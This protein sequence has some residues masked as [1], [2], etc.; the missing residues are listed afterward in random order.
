[1]ETVSL[2]HPSKKLIGRIAIGGSKS[3]SNRALIL[4]ALY[5]PDLVIEHL[6]DSKDTRTLQAALRDT[7]NTIDIG[8]AGTAM[9]FLTAYYAAKTGA[10]VTLKGSARMHQ[11][12]IGLLVEAL[13]GLDAEISYLKE[14]GY[15]PLHI[16][17][18]RLDKA[19][20]EIDGGVSSQFITALMLIAPSFEKG[21]T[22]TIKGFSVSTPYIYLTSGLMHRLGFSVRIQGEQVQIAPMDT[23]PTVTTL[24]VEPDWSSASYWFSMALLADQAELYLPFFRAVS[25]QGD[26][27]IRGLF[28]PLGVS[29]I[30]L[31][32]GFRLKKTEVTV[33]EEVH[34]NLLHAPDVAQTLA[35][36][37][38]AKGQQAVL[39]GLQTLSIKETDRLLALKTELEKC[40]AVV[41]IDADSLA[42]KKGIQSVEDVVFDTWGDHRMAMAFAPLALLGNIHINY[43]QVV[44]KSY[45]NFWEDLKSVGF[46]CVYAKTEA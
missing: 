12:P 13:R 46:R 11:R 25:M 29:T 34:L 30:G 3:E 23:I 21:L 38:A 4:Q 6:S 33:R 32:N 8:D 42:I 37:L 1:M 26:A 5:A 39:S 41:A 2:S 36:A 27:A 19:E 43:P 9:R 45:P 15:P 14:E 28:E 7:G 24:S 20:I 18:K 31:G 22:I 16:K 35:V 40:G 44:E 17:G 10:E